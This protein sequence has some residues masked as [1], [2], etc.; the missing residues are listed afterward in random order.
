MWN[1]SDVDKDG[2]MTL[3]EFC[4]AMHLT[5]L[6]L[7][8]TDLPASL[9]ESL[10]SFAA[11]CMSVCN[12]SRLFASDWPSAVSVFCIPRHA[13]G[14]LRSYFVFMVENGHVS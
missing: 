5:N 11:G 7:K 9:P 4:V 14:L 8:G 10:R 12:Q 13:N 2:Q 1:L 3:E 6:K